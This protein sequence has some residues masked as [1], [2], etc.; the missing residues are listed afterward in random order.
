M[1]EEIETNKLIDDFNKNYNISYVD[2]NLPIPANKD[3]LKHYICSLI[4]Y[5][6]GLLILIFNPF[7]NGLTQK[8]GNIGLS[9]IAIT[10]Y[11]LYLF[12]APIFLF[13]LK[14][15]TVFVSHNIDIVLYV[16]KVLNIK[17]NEKTSDIIN[18]ITPDYRQSQALMIFFIKFFF[19][20]Q[21][22]CWTLEHIQNVSTNYKNFIDTN[23]FL[24][25]QAKAY[26]NYV[27]EENIAR[28][29]GV[30]FDL[31][32]QFL[33]FIDCI[34]FSIG[35]CTELVIF[36]NRI[37]TVDTSFMGIFVCLMCYPPFN[38]ATSQFI[39][40][41]HN[42]SNFEAISVNANAI[43]VWILYILSLFLL[44]IYT[45]A[46][47]ALFTKASNLT[48]RGTVKIFPYNII[49]HPAYISKV[50]LWWIGSIAVISELID[51][52]GFGTVIL[53]L[54]SAFTWTFIYALR[55]VTE[56]K[57]LSKDPEYKQYMEKVKYRFIPYVW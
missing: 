26:G 42:E 33:Y 3:I 27:F 41:N 49:R 56:E 29:R 48:N 14:P 57:H 44:F 43:I 19:G 1:S 11:L 28:Y 36:N 12:I 21:L 6:I 30:I 16:L 35:Y 45:S 24:Q 18:R 51:F 47:I 8:V 9:N 2:E 17:K 55:A 52:N 46:S 25:E 7:Y 10:M 31:L 38:T 23:S 50:L 53:Y 15:K 54:C 22:I 4:V 40:W 32:V 39:A 5:G 13:T 34:I 37:R 20:P